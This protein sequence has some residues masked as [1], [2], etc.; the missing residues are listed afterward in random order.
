MISRS[1]EDIDQPT[2]SSSRSLIRVYNV[3]NSICT[4][5]R[6]A[7]MVSS[8][9]QIFPW[10]EFFGSLQCIWWHL[11]HVMRKPVY[12]TCEQQ[13]RRSAYASVQSDQRLCCS[14]P[15][16]YNTSSFYMQIPSLYLASVVAQAGLS[17][18]W[19]QTPKTGFLV[20][21][22]IYTW[23]APS[24]HIFKTCLFEPAHEIM[25]LFILRK[26]VLQTR[27]CSYPVGLDVWFLV[28]P[29]VYAHTLCV[30]T[31]KALAKCTGSP[32]PSLVI[33]VISTII[34]WTGSILSLKGYP[35]YFE[36][37]LLTFLY[38]IQC[39]AWSGAVF[40][41][42]WSGYTIAKVPFVSLWEK[43][44]S[45]QRISPLLIARSRRKSNWSFMP[46]LIT[47]KFDKLILEIPL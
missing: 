31:A 19:S 34:S 5:C 2:Y 35:V 16:Y 12:A 11:S 38:L 15:I 36:Y 27:M 6:F 25:V 26:L 30:R 45:T 41:W 20:T 47:C 7:S 22:L 23:W 3:C 32:K 14:L 9:V 44:F 40:W 1:R 24:M 42:V 37:F 33:Y 18:P 46:I 29:F 13:R 28:G 4:F 8:I 39:I 17:L 43:I 21:R 10:S